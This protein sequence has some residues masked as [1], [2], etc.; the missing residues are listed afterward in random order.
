MRRVVVTGIGAVSPLGNSFRDSWS[1]LIDGRCGITEIDCQGKRRRAGVLRGFD[2]CAYLTQKEAKRLDAF[3]HY[4]VAS[5][6]MALEDSALRQIPRSTLVI[7][8]SGRGGLGTLERY[9]LSGRPSAYM[10]SASTVAM[11]ASQAAKKTGL[12]GSALGIS[13]S[14]A[15]GVSA[16]GEAFL[17]IRNG[18][19]DV[20]LAGGAEA[21]VTRLCLEGYGAMGV[22]SKREVMMPF[23]VHRDGFLIG[24]GACAV[25]LEEY[26][27][28]VRRGARIYGEV[29][30][31]GR[32]VY[33]N[34][35]APESHAQAVA[36]SAALK[37]AGLK[38]EE[39]S[40]ISAHA[41]A[42]VAG[43]ASEA[44]AIRGVLGRGNAYVSAIKA[45][46]GHMIGA[47]GAFETAVALMALK[48]G[49]LP[50]TVNLKQPEFKLNFVVG[51]QTEAE[52]STA[53]VNSFG[54]GG[55]NSVLAL[56]AVRQ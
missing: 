28:A 35:A 1:A 29:A 13:N 43:D 26:G 25:L 51:G 10:M 23:D 14:C 48:S 49:I 36:M 40:Y 44:E 41:T 24:E 38:K 53:L 32:S 4:A 12:R 31:Y 56:K 21:P 55:V 5:C 19:V 6:V 7:I 54:F 3:V 8:G 2:P 16:I 27:R 50:P 39:I 17:A 9:Y 18:T 30:G 37:D 46:T 42:T 34:E 15:S 33:P 20:A 47:S 45:A 11:A 52:L 22:L